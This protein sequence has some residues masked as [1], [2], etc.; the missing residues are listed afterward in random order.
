MFIFLNSEVLWRLI[1]N[2]LR[3]ISLL[4]MLSMLS[5]ACLLVA[6]CNKYQHKKPDPTKGV[7][8]GVVMCADT[9]KPARFATVTLTTAPKAG[10][11]SDSGDPL[12]AAETTVTDLDGRFRLEAVPPGHYYAF[13]TLEV[14]LDP[15]LAVDPDKLRATSV[16]VEQ[17][18]YSIEQWK[19][20]LTEVTVVVRRVSDVS[21]QI[22]RGAEIAGTVTFD[23][24]SPA[25]GMH[26]QVFRKTE[27]GAW[28]DVG[29]SLMD[30]WT[31]HALS[32]GHGRFSITNL[33][34]GE[35]T[36]C[37][38]MPA[39]TEPSAP[40]VCLGNVFRRKNAKTVKVQAG[41]MAGG[42]DIEI[43]LTGLHTVSGN[44]TALVDGHALGKGTLRLLYADDREKMREVAL[45]EDGSFSFEYVPE[46]KYILRVEGAQ[47]ADVKGAEGAQGDQD[48]AAGKAA[49]V[50]RYADKEIPLTVQEDVVDVSMAVG[51]TPPDK[52]VSQ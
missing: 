5:I 50:V 33:Q 14:Y 11:K 51:V 38:L 3:W 31:M 1:L 45:E 6:G 46:G 24:A 12:P 25:I 44:V 16:G 21:I 29:L 18:R 47:D 15:T 34:A 32:D 13:A 2:R 35:Y 48:A 26:F 37:A 27:K 28:T 8:T 20:H 42:T 17:R 39:D 4:A 19:D 40:R 52:P 10:E 23:D 36:V 30:S 49:P 22:E 7:V 43:P 41:E 9:G